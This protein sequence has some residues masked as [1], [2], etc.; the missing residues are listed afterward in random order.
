MKQLPVDNEWEDTFKYRPWTRAKS[1]ALIVLV[2]SYSCLIKMS[3]WPDGRRDYHDNVIPSLPPR[4]FNGQSST[5]PPAQTV[6]YGY[7]PVGHSGIRNLY[8]DPAILGQW[9]PA[10]NDANAGNVHCGSVT[11]PMHTRNYND[12]PHSYPGSPPPLHST[13]GIGATPLPAPDVCRPDFSTFPA[14]LPQANF[15]DEAPIDM[16]PEHDASRNVTISGGYHRCDEQ[17]HLV[18]QQDTYNRNYNNNIITTHG[19]SHN[20]TEASRNTNHYHTHAPQSTSPP[21]AREKPTTF[22]THKLPDSSVIYIPPDPPLKHR[23]TKECISTYVTFTATWYAHPQAPAFQ[24]CSNCFDNSIRN[25]R[26]AGEFRG[27]WC[28]DGQARICRFSSP[29]IKDSL[30]EYALRSG[31]LDEMIQ[32]MSFRPSI[33]DC[34]SSRQQDDSITRWYR[35]RDDM[36]VICQACYEDKVLAHDADEQYFELINQQLQPGLFCAMAIP[37]INRAYKLFSNNW[38]SLTTHVSPRLSLP[39]CPGEKKVYPSGRWY[40]PVHGPLGFLIC[41]ACYHDYFLLTGQESGWKSAG[42]NIEEIFGVSVSCSLGPFNVRTLAT[43]MLDTA[44][45]ALF[46]KAVDIISPEPVCAAPDIMCGATW[47]TLF[48]NPAGF[49]VCRTC[50]ATVVEPLGVGRYFM[51]KPGGRRDGCCCFNPKFPRFEMYM[52][53]LMEMVY[54]R[55]PDPLEACVRTYASLPVCPRDRRVEKAR[56]YGWDECF[57]CPECHF[58]FIRG[59]AFDEGLQHRDVLVQEP[60]MCEMYS[61]RMRELYLVACGSD[62]PDPT[63]LLQDSLRRRA[64]F[65]E[66]MAR[67]R[68]F[69]EDE[70]R[71]TANGSFYNNQWQSDVP[72]EQTYEN[73]AARY[74]YHN[75][76]M[77]TEGAEYDHQAPVLGDELDG[78]SAAQVSRQLEEG[79]RAVE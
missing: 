59:T 38:S 4:D 10:R 39:P 35:T 45:Y 36:V 49:A 61:P 28:D 40:T 1:S 14:I 69:T 15:I 13:Q 68:Q 77:E 52:R 18:H 58:E 67:A 78:S 54:K 43:R 70:D 48:S 41:C 8:T 27:G 34:P 25:S 5:V 29:R 74:G 72:L 50:Y 20:P 31:S 37:Y 63:P 76:N 3:Y 51:L 46:W 79:W 75:Y 26:F 66:T 60:M 6:G 32:Y 64:V 33:P 30:F 16:Y 56:W 73:N 71:G 62:P 22:T 9:G 47:F 24:I 12:V 23:D 42:D 7:Q 44:D 21:A 2:S 17:A 19:S 53:K 55:D 57:I 65:A 11:F